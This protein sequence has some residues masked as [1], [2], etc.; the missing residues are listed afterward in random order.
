MRGAG[1]A[2]STLYFHWAPAGPLRPTSFKAEP[3]GEGPF[4]VWA[5]RVRKC[6]RSGLFDVVRE[7]M[8]PAGH[9]PPAARQDTFVALPGDAVE[10]PPGGWSVKDARLAH[11]PE[12]RGRSTGAAERVLRDPCHGYRRDHPAGPVLRRWRRRAG[13]SSGSRGH[14]RRGARP[15][16]AGDGQVMAVAAVA[17]ASVDASGLVRAAANGSAT[18][19]ATAGS[20]SGMLP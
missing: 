11:S 13:S 15:E 1:R 12:L 5:I 3:A 10:K 18:I 9:R 7:G 20:V 14:H 6:G 19:T 8:R 2:G 4:F 16:R 17:V